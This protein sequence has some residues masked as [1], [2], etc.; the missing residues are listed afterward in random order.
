MSYFF[1]IAQKAKSLISFW[2]RKIVCDRKHAKGRKRRKKKWQR[3]RMQGMGGGRFCLCLPLP[4]FNPRTTSCQHFL[5][6]FKESWNDCSPINQ[7]ADFPHNVTTIKFSKLLGTNNVCYHSMEKPLFI[8]WKQTMTSIGI[9]RVWG[10]GIRFGIFTQLI[11][12]RTR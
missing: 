7:S 8:S 2:Q 10:N 1:K 6:A 9:G 5:Q 12:R 11:D 3:L 4:P